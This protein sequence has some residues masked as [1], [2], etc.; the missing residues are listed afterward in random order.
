MDAI[1]ALGRFVRR[2]TGGLISR[3]VGGEVS[4]GFNAAGGHLFFKRGHETVVN[5]LGDDLRLN[6]LV[7][8]KSLLR[9]VKNNPAV[10][11]LRHV[12]FEVRLQFRV[13]R[14]IQVLT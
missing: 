3:F 10:G 6:A 11:A 2:E 12:R 5:V 7:D 8:L 9:G 14:L 4:G 13:Y 1:V